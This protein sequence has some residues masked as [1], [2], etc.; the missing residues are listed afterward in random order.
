MDKER[1]DWLLSFDEM[2]A[3]NLPRSDWHDRI[4][5]L[6]QREG[7]QMLERYARERAVPIKEKMAPRGYNKAERHNDKWDSD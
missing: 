7:A 1:A 4:R 5:L 3:F 6:R 2:S